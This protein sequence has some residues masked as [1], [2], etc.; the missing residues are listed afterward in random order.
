[1]EH[2]VQYE[3]GTVVTIDEGLSST[4][5]FTTTRLHRRSSGKT[6]VDFV[7]KRHVP[8]C[9]KS[10]TGS[11]IF[12]VLFEDISLIVRYFSSFS[13]LLVHPKYRRFSFE[14]LNDGWLIFSILEIWLFFNVCNSIFVRFR[15]KTRVEKDD[16][17][18]EMGCWTTWTVA[19]WFNDH[20]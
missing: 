5:H 11:W 16:D 15:T 4:F 6:S 9:V 8:R 17:A 10:S 20:Y 3:L 18:W 7:E 13:S 19:L 12:A 2:R 14:A 1:M